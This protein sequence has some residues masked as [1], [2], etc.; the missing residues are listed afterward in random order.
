MLCFY[1]IHK[2]AEWYHGL[3][4]LMKGFFHQQ[5]QDLHYKQL[6]VNDE[7]SI[8]FVNALMRWAFLKKLKQK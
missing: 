5:E 6:R 7:C 8:V 4:Q 3:F 2:Y 1:K